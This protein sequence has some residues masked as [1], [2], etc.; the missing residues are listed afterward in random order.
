MIAEKSKLKELRSLINN[1]EKTEREKSTQFETFQQQSSRHIADLEEKLEE[2]K[3]ANEE[4]RSLILSFETKLSAPAENVAVTV[5]GGESSKVTESTEKSNADASSLKVTK[6]EQNLAKAKSRADKFNK[7]IESMTVSLKEAEDK[8][9]MAEDATKALEESSLAEKQELETKL[10][11]K[12]HEIVALEQELNDAKKSIEEL[13]SIRDS[14]IENNATLVATASATERALQDSKDEFA[15][16]L[17]SLT[18]LIQQLELSVKEYDEATRLIN[19]KL[20]EVNKKYSET[21]ASLEEARAQVNEMDKTI[22]ALEGN[23][24]SANDSLRDSNK[25][26]ADA[27]TE[28]EQQKNTILQRDKAIKDV[29]GTLKATNDKL[30]DANQKYTDAKSEIEAL[31]YQNSQKDKHIEETEGNWKALNEKM[32]DMKQKFT[33][34]KAENYNLEK[35]SESKI[36]EL[37]ALLQSKDTDIN[38]QK[39]KIDQ[40]D[41]ALHDARSE[42]A[43]QAER[44]TDQQRALI[45]LTESARELQQQVESLSL[46]LQTTQELYRAARGEN[47]QLATNI[48]VTQHTR[49]E[50]AD[51]HRSQ[52][53]EQHLLFE[54]QLS[55]ARA[56]V[57]ALEL[58]VGNYASRLRMESDSADVLE[59][60]KKRAQLALKKA[61]S[62]NGQLTVENAQLKSS[63]DE[64]K[65]LLEEQKAALAAALRENLRFKEED[66]ARETRYRQLQDTYEAELSAAKASIASLTTQQSPS[67]PLY[68]SQP[69]KRPQLGARDSSD[70]SENASV[71]GEMVIN[72]RQESPPAAESPVAEM[73]DAVRVNSSSTNN[74]SPGRMSHGSQGP[75][76]WAILTVE[77]SNAAA[78][79]HPQSSPTLE[80][81]PTSS[82]AAIQGDSLDMEYVEIDGKNEKDEQVVSAEHG[83]GVSGGKS[84]LSTALQ[85]KLET[86]L[87]ELSQ[88]GIELEASQQEL[89]AERMERKKT[90]TRVE[91]LLAFLERSKQLQGDGPDS[92]VNMEYLKNCV[93]RFMASSYSDLSEKKRL[94]PVISMILKLTAAERKQVEQALATAMEEQSSGLELNSTL[95]TIGATFENLWGWGSSAPTNH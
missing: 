20:K 39:G 62:S 1:A 66:A 79:A 40:L 9:K 42:V 70:E 19:D 34:T 29:E 95:N 33:D 69:M 56:T 46:E 77:A 3:A 36:I 59:N 75:K 8:V 60:Y 43:E 41:R 58:E 72:I 88:R 35:H 76:S 22:R 31:K 50:M 11:S 84:M 21:R 28:S 25:R 2:M 85:R 54:Q 90:Q 32:K 61:N 64:I 71:D 10:E 17:E 13:H 26:L 73:S 16:E 94:Y 14:L 92:A 49:D 57:N 18:N 24:K 44:L 27:K 81:V 63:V 12:D 67:E 51:I 38:L 6:L 83:G 4:Q 91:E 47:E 93:C 89:V 65:V 86:V 80:K 48:H 23:L 87:K 53:E 82:P 7:K 78:A 5:E 30:K 45:R 37:S 52:M 15:Q 74:A 68:R 55:A